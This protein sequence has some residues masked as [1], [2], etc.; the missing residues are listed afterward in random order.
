MSGP[1]LKVIKHAC[2]SQRSE[3]KILAEYEFG[4]IVNGEGV[5]KIKEIAIGA[6]MGTNGYPKDV[7]T[8]KK[9]TIEERK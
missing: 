6:E 4:F 7:I 3:Q 9:V 2:Y 1:A 8:L 5:Q